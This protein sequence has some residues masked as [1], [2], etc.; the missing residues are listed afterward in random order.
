MCE[1]LVKFWDRNINSFFKYYYFD[2]F[3][4]DYINIK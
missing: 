1:F 4:A 2:N 3:S